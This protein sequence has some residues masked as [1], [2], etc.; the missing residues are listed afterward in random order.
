MPVSP[1]QCNWLEYQIHI[2]AVVMGVRLHFPSD[3]ILA[4]TSQLFSCDGR[5]CLLG[6][7]TFGVWTGDQEPLLAVEHKRAVVSSMKNNYSLGL[8][9]STPGQWH[10]QRQA[11]T[12]WKY[13][14]SRRMLRQT[15]L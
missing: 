11:T 4:S 1:V 8:R 15:F 13:G 10:N 6:S 5:A 14:P 9:N 12:F 2:C 3:D 7:S